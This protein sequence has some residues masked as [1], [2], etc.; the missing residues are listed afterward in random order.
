MKCKNCG[1]SITDFTKKCEYCGGI[2]HIVQK[3]AEESQPQ[4]PVKP[5]IHIDE[6]KSKLW[7]GIL[8]GLFFNFFGF[9]VGYVLFREGTLAR[10]TFMKGFKIVVY[11]WVAMLVVYMFVSI[12]AF[13][14]FNFVFDF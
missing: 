3:Q 9:I 8:C 2:E 10:Q 14:S 5:I 7:L 6:T 13:G 4:E 12:F 1:A 11:G